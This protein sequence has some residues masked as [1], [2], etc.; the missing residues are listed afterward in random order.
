MP[1]SDGRSIRVHLFVFQADLIKRFIHPCGEVGVYGLVSVYTSRTS[2]LFK[3]N[4][5]DDSILYLGRAHPR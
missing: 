4:N 3:K 1:L 5:G 2:D